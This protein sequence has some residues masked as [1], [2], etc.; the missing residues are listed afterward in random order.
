[1]RTRD[2]IDDLTD[3]YINMVVYP[4]DEINDESQENINPKKDF[5]EM[6]KSIFVTQ[7]SFYLQGRNP[8]RGWLQG[9]WL[10]SFR[11]PE[12]ISENSQAIWIMMHTR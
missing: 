12:F 9:V 3:I 6:P 5:I 11:K 8:C 1:M 7:V 4:E 10:T 2:D